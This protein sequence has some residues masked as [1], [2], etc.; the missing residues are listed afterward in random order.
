MKPVEAAGPLTLRRIFAWPLLLALLSAVGLL[1]ALLGDGVWDLLSWVA[2]GLP[3]V[4]MLWHVLR[5]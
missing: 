4:V 2:L 1:S 5:A 3:L